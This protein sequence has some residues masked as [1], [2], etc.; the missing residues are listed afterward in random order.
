MINCPN[1]EKKV[2]IDSSNEYRPI[3]IGTVN[4]YFFFTI[5]AINHYLQELCIFYEYLLDSLKIHL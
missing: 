3:F 5:W 1:C 2:S 4:A